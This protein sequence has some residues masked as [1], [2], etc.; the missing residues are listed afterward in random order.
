MESTVLG[1]LGK[2]KQE[3]EAPPNMSPRIV[4][5]AN[6]TAA[7]GDGS[8]CNAIQAGQAQILYGRGVCCHTQNSGSGQKKTA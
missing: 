8:V 3:R 1:S 2:S 5:R 6:D 7:V 4:S